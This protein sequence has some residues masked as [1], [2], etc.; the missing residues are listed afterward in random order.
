MFKLVSISAK[1]SF[2]LVKS[3]AAV[4]A[5]PRLLEVEYALPQ[6]L[7][8]YPPAADGWSEKNI[9][10]CHKYCKKTCNLL[11]FTLIQIVYKICTFY[12]L[13]PWFKTKF[14]G[15]VA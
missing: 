1:E 10:I 9:T 2:F 8:L 5:F 11:K 3:D 4:R 12:L 6:I 13:T 7:Q 15:T 14:K